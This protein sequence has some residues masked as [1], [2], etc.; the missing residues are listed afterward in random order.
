MRMGKV[1]I[2]ILALFG[3]S[4]CELQDAT[5]QQ[6]TVTP[7]EVYEQRTR[8]DVVIID[9]RTPEEFQME[10]I[11]EALNKPLQTIQEWVNTLPKDKKIYFVCRSGNR[12]AQAQRIA[13]QAGY[14]NTYNMQGGM[15][16]WKREGLPVVSGR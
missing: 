1:L 8:K 5:A 14:E 11:R 12:S 16:A 4:A 7:R 2:G 6:K 9:V 3:L 13:Q 10:R 15:L